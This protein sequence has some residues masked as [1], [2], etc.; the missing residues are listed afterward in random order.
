MN[1][2][3]EKRA[4]K[5]TNGNGLEIIWDWCTDVAI[6][7]ESLERFL[8]VVFQ[9]IFRERERQEKREKEKHT[10]KTEH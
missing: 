7:A 5:I 1:Y 10:C 6:T 2:E 4:T 8:C 9:L 3:E